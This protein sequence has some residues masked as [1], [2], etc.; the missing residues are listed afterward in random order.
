MR[1]TKT[2]E[3]TPLREAASADPGVMQGRR[4]SCVLLKEVFD[5]NDWNKDGH[6]VCATLN[7]AAGAYQGGRAMAAGHTCARL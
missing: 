1:V 4:D 2:K 5:H 7:G 6:G 3:F